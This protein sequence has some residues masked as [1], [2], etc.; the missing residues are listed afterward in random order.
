MAVSIVCLLVCLCLLFNVFVCMAVYMAVTP[1][2]S[3]VCVVS[4]NGPTPFPDWMS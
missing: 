3:G 1:C 2:G 4:Q